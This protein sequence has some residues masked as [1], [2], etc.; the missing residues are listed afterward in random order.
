MATTRGR[1]EP[2]QGVRYSPDGVVL[3]SNAERYGRFEVNAEKLAE[4]SEECRELLATPTGPLICKF[5]VGDVGETLDYFVH[6]MKGPETHADPKRLGEVMNCDSYHEFIETRLLGDRLKA[7]GFQDDVLRAILDYSVDVELDSDD[8]ENWLPRAPRGSAIYELLIDIFCHQ[9]GVNELQ[10]EIRV[11][12]R[13]T[14]QEVTM[15]LMQEVR[16]YKG[17]PPPQL[18]IERYIG[19]Y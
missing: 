5:Y 9:L 8:L 7:R 6:W 10:E 15:R 3:E 2:V 13:D 4:Y 12:D 16:R 14:L 1:V 18:D 11:L 17:S 19:R